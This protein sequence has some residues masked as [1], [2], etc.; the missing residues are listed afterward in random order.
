VIRI[1]EI[2]ELP[3]DAHAVPLLGLDEVLFEHAHQDLARV[4][5]ERVLPQLDDRATGI[6]HTLMFDLARAERKSQFREK[7]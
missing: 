1:R 6:H 4:R 5:V 7:A 3:E 2:A